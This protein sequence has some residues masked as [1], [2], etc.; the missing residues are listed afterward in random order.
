MSLQ[1]FIFQRRPLKN[2]VHKVK[3]MFLVATAQNQ[4][5]FVKIANGLRIFVK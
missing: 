5:L 3:I 4:Y 2:S 1:D